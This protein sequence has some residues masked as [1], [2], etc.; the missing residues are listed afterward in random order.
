MG[1]GAITDKD[2]AKIIQRIVKRNPK[3][4]WIAYGS[5]TLPNFA[6]A[7]GAHVFNGVKYAPE[8]NRL[9]ILDPES[10][11]NDVYNRYAN[12]GV[13]L[14][15]DVKAPPEFILLQ[16]DAYIIKIHPCSDLLKQLG[17]THYIFPMKM[18]E[19]D[20]YCLKQVNKNPINGNIFIYRRK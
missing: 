6:R 3:S 4:Y 11:Y 12:I 9:A 19:S 20:S 2:L 17:I 10:K 5:G 13:N 16:T 18:S 1:I 15:S 8:F 14:L 7:N